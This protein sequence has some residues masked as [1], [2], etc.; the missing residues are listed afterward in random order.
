MNFWKLILELFSIHDP[1]VDLVPVPPISNP[2][3]MTNSQ[4]LYLAAKA[5]L[6]KDMV[7]DPTVDPALGCAESVNEVFK[8]AFGKEI[9]GGS[10]TAELYQVLKTDPRFKEATAPA[11]GY[12]VISPTGTSTKSAPHGHVGIYGMYGI[13]S[14]NSMTGTFQEYYTEQSWH[15]YYVEKLGFPMFFFEVV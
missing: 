6:G 7:E 15:D 9:G 5:C 4:K 10:S 14:N 2:T 8:L 13:L 12:I 1:H 3:P 11:A